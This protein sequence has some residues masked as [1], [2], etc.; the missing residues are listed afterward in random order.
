MSYTN[1]SGVD[2]KPGSPLD[3]RRMPGLTWAVK[4]TTMPPAKSLIS[5]LRTGFKIRHFE[6]THGVKTQNSIT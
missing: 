6:K 3:S 2:S 4:M 5:V 1:F